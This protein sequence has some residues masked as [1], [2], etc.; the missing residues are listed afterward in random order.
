MN[1]AQIAEIVTSVLIAV[2]AFTLLLVFVLTAPRRNRQSAERQIVALLDARPNGADD[3]VRVRW[4]DGGGDGRYRGRGTVWYREDGR[5]ATPHETI[6]ICA[7][8]RRAQW[9]TEEPN[10]WWHT[11]QHKSPGTA[12]GMRPRP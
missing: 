9:Q 2:A 4:S 5:P 8:L 11:E 10:P 1:I 7:A 3:L 6:E 12:T